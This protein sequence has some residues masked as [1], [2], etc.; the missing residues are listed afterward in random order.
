VPINELVNEESNGKTK[1]RQDLLYRINTVEITLPP[2]RDRSEDVPALMDHFVK[3]YCR[4][5][6]KPTMKIDP[7]LIRKLRTY[8]WPGNIRELQHSV[9]KAVI[10]TEGN[11][12]DDLRH[13]HQGDEDFMN[14]GEEPK[15]L[16]DMEK[17]M[18]IK[19]VRHH[20]GNLSRV[21]RELGI[22]RATL[23]RKMEKFK[24]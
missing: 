4:K 8:E 1:F 5:Y 2:L 13:F 24:L 15:T 7:E 20:T 22:T 17:A 9:E 6:Q 3:M 21:A 16:E 11:A 14:L 12:I 19:S 23:Y 18:I 10:L